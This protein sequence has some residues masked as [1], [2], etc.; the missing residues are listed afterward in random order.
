[1][2]KHQ[3]AKHPNKTK[4]TACWRTKEKVAI[5]TGIQEKKKS[6]H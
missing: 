2:K 4:H 1:M 6:Q 5:H 3:W